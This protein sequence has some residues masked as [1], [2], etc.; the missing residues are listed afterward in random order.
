MLGQFALMLGKADSPLDTKNLSD[1]ASA[2][3]LGH[4]VAVGESE[5]LTRPTLFETE[6]F[7]TP[8]CLGSKH[9]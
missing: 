2:K 6:I 1:I 9:N 5:N 3:T 8:Y 4:I 7:Y